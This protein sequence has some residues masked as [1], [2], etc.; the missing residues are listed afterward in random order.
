[1]KA[2]EMDDEPTI[3][4]AA[5]EAEAVRLYIEH[6]GPDLLDREYYPRELTEEELDSPQPELDEDERPTGRTVS[7]RKWLAEATEPGWL[8][9]AV[10]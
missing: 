1:M 2:Y 10:R 5:G 4:A 6:A 9:A 8:C 3:Y 7:I